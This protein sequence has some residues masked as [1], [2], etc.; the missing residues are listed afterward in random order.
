V[1]VVEVEEVGV[2]VVGEQVAVAEA[3]KKERLVGK[4]WSVREV[5]VVAE[6]A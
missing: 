2:V 3:V 1:V 6:V 4:H 5:M